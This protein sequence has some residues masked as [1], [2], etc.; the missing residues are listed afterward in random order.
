[1][2]S[3]FRP[4][5]AAIERPSDVFPTP[6]GPTKQRIPERASGLSLRTARNSRMRSFTFSMS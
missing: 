3:N 1:M 4:I 6:G 5:A 2:R